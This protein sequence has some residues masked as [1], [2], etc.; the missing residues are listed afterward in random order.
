MEDQDVS[1]RDHL[2]VHQEASCFDCLYYSF[3]YEV[4]FSLLRISCIGNGQ[5]L[6][7]G[8][9]RIQPSRASPVRS[10]K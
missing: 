1:G 7:E 6:I 8:P 3:H 9:L 4:E 10:F 5:A 2:R